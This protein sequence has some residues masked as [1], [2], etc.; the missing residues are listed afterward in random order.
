MTDYLCRE[1][2]S[3]KFGLFSASTVG[4]VV[5]EV[6]PLAMKSHYKYYQQD[7]L[8]SSVRKI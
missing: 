3:D 2:V 4:A 6:G 1:P 5:V 8:E 7:Q